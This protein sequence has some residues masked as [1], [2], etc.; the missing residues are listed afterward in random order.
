[1]PNTQAYQLIMIFHGISMY[2][3][4]V[5]IYILPYV[6]IKATTSYIPQ[7]TPFASL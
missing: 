4:L 5:K 2:N 3:A 6:S 1:M 7:G